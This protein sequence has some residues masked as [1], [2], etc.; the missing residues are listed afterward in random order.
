MGIFWGI[1]FRDFLSLNHNLVRLRYNYTNNVC[2][3]FV[4]VLNTL[5]NNIFLQIHHEPIQ[6]IHQAIQVLAPVLLS[7]TDI[8]R[9]TSNASVRMNKANIAL[10]KFLFLSLPVQL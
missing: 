9:T 4:T 10:V 3:F 2:V 7:S 1:I 8:E 6:V 5:L